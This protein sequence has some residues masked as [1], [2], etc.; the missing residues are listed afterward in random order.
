[1]GKNKKKS[2]RD[3]SRVLPFAGQ[4]K[5]TG[6]CTAHRR[7]AC[8]HPRCATLT[9]Y[10]SSDS[11]P[12]HTDLDDLLGDGVTPKIAVLPCAGQ[13]RGCNYMPHSSGKYNGYCCGRCRDN[14]GHGKLCEASPVTAVKTEVADTTSAAASQPPPQPPPPL[15]VPPP[16]QP[17]WRG[18]GFRA[19]PNEIKFLGFCCS[20]C[21]DGEGHNKLCQGIPVDAVVTKTGAGSS[22]D[23]DVKAET[24]DVKAETFDVKAETLD[25]ERR[26]ESFKRGST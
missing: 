25:K 12:D 13:N 22:T 1:M 11:Q 10:Q 5:I 8:Q 15:M 18:C 17:C 9:G 3:W 24:P 21:E 6:V 20:T 26:Q 19:H 7:A 14:T 16:C 2:K 23:V 4:R